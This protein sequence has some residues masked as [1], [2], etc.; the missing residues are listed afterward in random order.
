MNRLRTLVGTDTHRNAHTHPDVGVKLM[1]CSSS[2][3]DAAYGNDPRIKKFKDEE[4]S[5]KESEK[6]AK[7]EAKK[8]EQEEKERVS[9]LFSSQ[10]EHVGIFATADES[11]CRSFPKTYDVFY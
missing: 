6:K 8:R 10:R 1:A 4:K 5:R 3:V 2:P 11:S 7:V 9:R